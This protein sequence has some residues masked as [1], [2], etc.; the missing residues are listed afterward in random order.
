LLATYLKVAEIIDEEVQTAVTGA[1]SKSTIGKL[2]QWDGGISA[3]ILHQ[4]AA[5]H[6]AV[7]C[8]AYQLLDYCVTPEIGRCKCSGIKIPRYGWYTTIPYPSSGDVAAS[9]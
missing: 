1:S 8:A 4:S 5:I 7:G 2:R 9:V 6:S 3:A